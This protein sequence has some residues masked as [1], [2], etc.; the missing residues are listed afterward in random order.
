MLN[1]RCVG[2]GNLLL[3]WGII[4]ESVLANALIQVMTNEVSLL[5]VLLKSGEIT[6]YQ[7]LFILM[8]GSSRDLSKTSY[9]AECYST[10]PTTKQI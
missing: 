1:E 9:V 5:Q 4:S 6:M 3:Q 2:I 10:L 8:E 7:H